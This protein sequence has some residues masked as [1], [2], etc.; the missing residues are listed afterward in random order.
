L[1]KHD[2]AKLNAFMAEPFSY[3]HAVL[4]ELAKDGGIPRWQW[5]SRG[6]REPWRRVFEARSNPDAPG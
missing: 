1:I 3:R 2:R 5:I 6:A 4:I